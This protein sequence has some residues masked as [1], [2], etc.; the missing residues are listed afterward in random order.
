[1][2]GDKAYGHG[3]GDKVTPARQWTVLDIGHITAYNHLNPGV[4]YSERS[5][6]YRTVL[7]LRRIPAKEIILYFYGNANENDGS[8]EVYDV[9]NSQQLCEITG[10]TNADAWHNSGWTAL[11]S[12][13]L[14]TEITITLRHKGSS[15]TEDIEQDR[16]TVMVRR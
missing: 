3:S 6:A 5:Q 13:I 9:T 7:D 14:G 4:A 12:S 15:A 16:L 8:I 11:P 10:I 2:S 1:M